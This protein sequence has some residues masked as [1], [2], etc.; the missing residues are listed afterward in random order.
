MEAPVISDSALVPDEW[1]LFIGLD[2]VVGID[3]FH[4]N[5]LAQ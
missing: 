1:V 5:L 2:H 3:L 4:S